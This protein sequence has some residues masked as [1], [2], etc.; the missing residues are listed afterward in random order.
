MF[1]RKLLFYIFM[2]IFK[3]I[4]QNAAIGWFEISTD[5]STDLF[6]LTFPHTKVE[7]YLK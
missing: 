1:G 2:M 7:R 3:V 5:T 6:S 4:L